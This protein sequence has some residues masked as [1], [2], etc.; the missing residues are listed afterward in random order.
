MHLPFSWPRALLGRYDVFHAHWPETLVRHPWR[1]RRTLRRLATAALLVRLRHRRTPVVRTLHNLAPH[2]PG[3]R[4]EGRLLA[5]LDDL[6]AAYVRLNDRTPA[7][8]RDVPV[9]TIPLGHYVERFAPFGRPDPEPGLLVYAGFVRPYK[10]VEELIDAFAALPSGSPWRLRIV[11][12]PTDAAHGDRVAARAAAVGG[13]TTRLVTVPDA[14]LVAELAS[15]E[16]VVLPYRQLHNSAMLMAALSV[17]RP[18][19]VPAT[20]TTRDLA[21]EVG[22]GWVT[23]Y[24]GPLDGE[25]LAAALATARAAPRPRPPVLEGRDWA[26]HARRHAEV[27]ASVVSERPPF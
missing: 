11:G 4:V 19:V 2:E 13:V 3:D 26:T 14:D 6:V 27:Y 7:P 12:R 22:P 25:V 10:G 16:V 24:E 18:V 15:A 17:G 21:A 23:T 8:D 9:T 1:V 20:P 5:R